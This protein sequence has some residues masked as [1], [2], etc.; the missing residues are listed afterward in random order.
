MPDAPS[1][2]VRTA[3]FL[4]SFDTP[5]SS[6]TRGSFLRVL[7]R[8]RVAPLSGYRA[9]PLGASA[10]GVPPSGRWPVC[11]CRRGVADSQAVRHAP[12]R[13]IATPIATPVGYRH[14]YRHQ[15]ILSYDRARYSCAQVGR[16]GHDERQD[17]PGCSLAEC[18]VACFVR[19][20][21]GDS[22]H[23][24]P[25]KAA[26][27]RLPHVCRGGHGLMRFVGGCHARR[28]QRPRACR[29]SE[30]P[31]PRQIVWQEVARPVHAAQR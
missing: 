18:L 29:L 7:C 8:W 31:L 5:Q 17:R 22:P 20:A 16:C 1:A 14:F 24:M 2:R 28:Q 27:V 30:M 11:V 12:G 3:R 10:R 6:M 13:S 9:P 15:R 23:P 26:L 25:E 19:L 21:L 4:D